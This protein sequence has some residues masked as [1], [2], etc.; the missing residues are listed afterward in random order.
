MVLE[1]FNQLI[2]LLPVCS[3]CNWVASLKDMKNV[4]L[5]LFSSDVAMMAAKPKKRQHSTTQNPKNQGQGFISQT[6]LYTYLVMIMYV[7][8]VLI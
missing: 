3:G 7:F 4:A 6:P 2:K 1:S 5:F 8:G